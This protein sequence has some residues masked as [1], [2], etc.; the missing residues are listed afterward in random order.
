MLVSQIY[1]LDIADNVVVALKELP[2]GNI[3]LG[4]GI[5]D[6]QAVTNLNSEK[7]N[8]KLFNRYI[9]CKRLTE[10]VHKDIYPK[11]D[12]MK[13]LDDFDD[14]SL[15]LKSCYLGKWFPLALAEYRVSK[16]QNF[17][18]LFNLIG[19]DVERWVTWYNI[20]LNPDRFVIKLLEDRRISLDSIGAELSYDGEIVE[21]FH[22]G[23]LYGI[24]GSQYEQ[25]TDRFI[26]KL[27]EVFGYHFDSS[28]SVGVFK[29]YKAN[30]YYELHI[31][32][33]FDIMKLKP[34]D[35]KFLREQ[36]KIIESEGS[37]LL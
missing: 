14:M 11:I 24:V 34:D 2:N 29:R 6:N 4:L 35:L 37:K 25:I 5:S 8:L 3:N 26:K 7:N 31:W 27:E 33:S 17:I 15:N 19:I 10:N 36:W 1:L 20:N 22:E 9:D 21:D 30:I 23:F 16:W 18:G 13:F 28:F 12:L 32:D